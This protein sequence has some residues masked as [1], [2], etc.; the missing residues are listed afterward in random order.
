[1]RIAETQGPCSGIE[2]AEKEKKRCMFLGTELLPGVVLFVV[3][4]WS[5]YS[6]LSPGQWRSTL[7]RAPFD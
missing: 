1:M 4:K 5:G 7:G 3:G 2:W 6:V